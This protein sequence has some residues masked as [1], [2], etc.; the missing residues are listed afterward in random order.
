[1]KFRFAPAS[2]IILV[3]F[4]WDTNIPAAL[5]QAMDE[6][7][8]WGSGSSGHPPLPGNIIPPLHH[9]SNHQQNSHHLVTT[10]IFH[11]TNI[12]SF[13]RREDYFQSNVLESV[14]GTR[15]HLRTC[16]YCYG[17]LG[18]ITKVAFHN[19]L[20]RDYLWI[21]TPRCT[22]CHSCQKGEERREEETRRRASRWRLRRDQVRR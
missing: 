16:F 15:F 8:F 20:G 14:L 1:M 19:F 11:T 12:E 18:K 10:H 17:F 5:V 21:R 22:K 3:P 6:D 4:W 9:I 13:R 7:P 2:T